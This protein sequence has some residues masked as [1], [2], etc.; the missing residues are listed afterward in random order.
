MI[1]TSQQ[2]RDIIDIVHPRLLM[3]PESRASE[4]PYPDKWSIK[5]TLGHLIDSVANNHQRVVRMQEKENIGFF[6]YSQEHW[7]KSQ[8]YQTEAW[9][10]LVELWQR[11]NFH[12]AHIIGS[13][14]PGAL[15]HTCDTGEA[16]PIT[17][18]FMVEDYLHHLQHHIDQ[19]LSDSDPK[20]RKP[21][22]R[23]PV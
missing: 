10:D 1:N 22:E 23:R 6:S 15:N 21:R 14:E 17:L 13:I 7:V 3:I 9:V 18:K 2:L 20:D 5:E 4:K 12:L 16:K 8:H 19:I 11:Y